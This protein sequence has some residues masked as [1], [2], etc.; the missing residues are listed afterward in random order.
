MNFAFDNIE[1]TKLAAGMALFLISGSIHELAH[2]YISHQL[3]GKSAGKTGYLLSD[4]PRH[5]DIS[6]AI[7]FPLL[8]ALSNLP[9]FG[10]MRSAPDDGQYK[11]KPGSE[12]FILLA[13]PYGNLIQALFGYFL[14]K[15]FL[16]TTSTG[17]F[18]DPAYEIIFRYTFMYAEINFILALFNLLPLPPLDG[19]SLAMR[20]LPF[21]LKKRSHLFKVP[22]TVILFLLLIS[23]AFNFLYLPVHRFVE[24]MFGYIHGTSVFA[25][26][27]LLIAGILIP[28]LLTKSK[29]LRNSRIDFREDLQD[30]DG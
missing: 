16:L 24:N 12:T 6:G 9:L 21:H 3:A 4:N 1:I 10:W 26:L 30:E 29:S 5:L 28:S 2:G 22:G 27:A 19:G 23:G 25:I 18:S 11:L 20:L 13:G 14:T 8:G 7:I 15:V 17:L